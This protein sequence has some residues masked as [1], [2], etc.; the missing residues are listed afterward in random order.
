[1]RAGPWRECWSF[2]GFIAAS[3]KRDFL[4][5]YLGTQLGWV[6]AV[7]QPLALILIYTLVF[8]QIMRPALPGDDSPFAYSIYL[9]TGIILWQLFADLINR[10]VGMFV[11]N[12]GLLKKARV[13]KLALPV[14]AV[15][16]ALVSF[17][18]I[19]AL[20]AVFLL[21]IGRWPGAAALSVLP[22]IALVVG[23]AAGLGVLL[24]TVNV[25]YRD[26]EQA[27]SMLLQFGFWLTPIVY[28]ARAIPDVL[29]SVLAWNPLWPL[30]SFAQAIFLGQGVSAWSVLA[31][32]AAATLLCL[33]AGW[34]AFRRL[35]PDIQDEL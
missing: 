14:I 30:V 19:A 6:W 33:A 12:A 34:L 2:R 24:A 10:F 3:V 5:R 28:P 11:Q 17:L 25:F 13:P 31:Y 8:A 15:L 26:V 7:A 1:M 4:S 27:T 9:C 23:I 16:S 32:P 18:I 29:A 22:V 21:A 20:F 35:A